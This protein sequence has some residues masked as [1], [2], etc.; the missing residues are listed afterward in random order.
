M[1]DHTMTAGQRFYSTSALDSFTREDVL[2]GCVITISP[3]LITITDVRVGVEPPA[4][5]QHEVAAHVARLLDHGVRSFHVDINFDDYSGFGRAAPDCN[6]DVFTPD[7]VADLNQAVR[8]RD[9]FLTVHL[10]T[11]YP[12]RHLRDFAP[13]EIG[14]I[15]FQ[16]DAVA[17]AAQ[18]ADLVKYIH[19]MGACASP[20][21]ETVGT[22]A[23]TPRSPAEVRA[24]LDPV[25]PQ[26]GMLTF[27]ATGTAARSNRSAAAFAGKRVAAYLESLPPGFGG[28]LQLQGGIT[29]ETTAAAVRR[30]A[31]FLVAGTQIFRNR[32]G[33]APTDVIDAMLRAAA[34]ALGV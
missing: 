17:D 14:A 22:D 4:G 20:V 21:I 30:G 7:F 31:S 24:L 1:H 11:G 5:L 26:I 18:L 19:A 25:L 2:A 27:Q 23:L 33:L 13:I 15:C 9:A 34:A 29:V 12:A 28:T 10:L 16:L 3:A 32:A 6:A 8:A